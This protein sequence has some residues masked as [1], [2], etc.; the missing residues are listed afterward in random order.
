MPWHM[1]AVDFADGLQCANHWDRETMFLVAWTHGWSLMC[2]KHS[3]SM[4]F[5]ALA[6]YIGV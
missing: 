1:G 4:D 2:L 5:V 6:A 3:G